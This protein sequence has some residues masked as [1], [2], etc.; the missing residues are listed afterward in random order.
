MNY[1]CSQIN[2]LLK[3]LFTS[4]FWYVVIIVIPVSMLGIWWP[5]FFKWLNY[6]SYLMPESWFT[7]GVGSLA[8][9]S[10]E[11]L[12]MREDDDCFKYPNA[13]IIV[14]LSIVGALFYGKALL[15]ELKSEEHLPIFLDIG[16]LGLAII[17]NVFVWVWNIFSRNTYDSQN[18]TNSLGESYDV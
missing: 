10:I 17:I 14:A 5:V 3:A 13:I 15:I 8:V 9:I 11:R 4:S 2:R 18:A 16:Y 6:D 7:F 12:F 1:F